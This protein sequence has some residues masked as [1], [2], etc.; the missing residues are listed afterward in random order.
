TSGGPIE[1]R[2]FIFDISTVGFPTI[3]NNCTVPLVV[4]DVFNVNGYMNKPGTGQEVYFENAAIPG[5]IIQHGGNVWARQLDVETDSTHVL[6]DGAKF[7]VL[8][9]KTEGNGSR[10]LGFF[11][12]RNGGSSEILGAFNS[13]PGNGRYD[14]VGYTAVDSGMSLAGLSTGSELRSVIREEQKGRGHEYTGNH[15]RYGGSAIPLFTTGRPA[16]GR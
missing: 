16:G 8:G 9:Y 2:G 15:V 7:W 5:G 14:T 4:A 1:I 11:Y 10:G 12:T 6:N 13:T 3:Q